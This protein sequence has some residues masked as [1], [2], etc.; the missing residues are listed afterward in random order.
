MECLCFLN[1][2]GKRNDLAKY[3]GSFCSALRWKST[4]PGEFNFFLCFPDEFFEFSF[5]PR[6]QNQIAPGALG[7]GV[8]IEKNLKIEDD[9]TFLYLKFLAIENCRPPSIPLALLL[10]IF[11]NNPL[12]FFT[13][14]NIGLGWGRVATMTRRGFP[15]CYMAKYY[16]QF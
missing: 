12:I 3:S 15:Y 9:C 14:L 7:Q 10:I 16:S 6:C 2:I 8:S 4:G 11:P 1:I 13:F 5:N